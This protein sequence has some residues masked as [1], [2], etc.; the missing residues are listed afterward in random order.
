MPTTE[1]PLART[2]AGPSAAEPG[3]L[4]RDRFELVE[5][6]AAG[7]MG[8]VWRALDRRLERTVAVKLLHPWLASQRRTVERFQQEA[9]AMARLTHGNLVEVYDVGHC[10]GRRYL[11]M[12][13]VAGG[14]VAPLLDGSPLPV[15]EV[16]SIGAQAAA[17]LAAA[18]EAGVIHRDVTPGNLLLDAS[19][20]VKV[21][22]FG[23]ARLS[24]SPSQ[25]ARTGELLG[26]I[27]YL[28]PE[29]LTGGETT[30]RS[31]VYALG[32]VL[33]QA[34]TGHVPFEADTPAASGLARLAQEL[35][36]PRDLRRSVPG[37]LAE[38]IEAATRADAERRPNAAQVAARLHELT[39]P[40]PAEHLRRTD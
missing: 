7:G 29:Q 18:H 5:H 37:A 38:V 32:L 19:G 31:D 39:G 15:L 20:R 34:A 12:E 25:T 27:V 8:E 2:S 11:V 16:A 35:P 1:G 21:S 26:S 22:D 4:L 40:R 36:S 10:T 17:G 14:S 9:V 30:P 28:A 23:I 6:I 24:G 3:Q 13:F 33:W